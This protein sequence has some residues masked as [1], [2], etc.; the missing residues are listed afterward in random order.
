[1]D[2]VTFKDVMATA[3]LPQVD[4]VALREGVDPEPARRLGLPSFVKPARLGSSV[5][6]SKVAS[7]SD[8]LPALATAFAHDPLVIVEAMAD[9]AAAN[10]VTPATHHLP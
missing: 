10:P 9:V 6:I 7:E 3:G 1:M 8:L 4:Y 5:G 2:K